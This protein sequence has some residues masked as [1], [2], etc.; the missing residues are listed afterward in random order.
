M[1]LVKV[2]NSPFLRDTH[3]RVLLNTDE[4]AKNEYLT[5]VKLLNTQ[6]DEIN[7]VKSDM[8]AVK[9]DM[10]EIK[11]LLFKLLEKGSNG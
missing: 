7:T 2:T 4:N 10:M 1:P 9:Q 8:I 3:S 5:K 11:Q 6:K